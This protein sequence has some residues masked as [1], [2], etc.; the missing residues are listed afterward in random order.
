MLTVRAARAYLVLQGVAVLAFWA[1]PI[2]VTHSNQAFLPTAASPIFIYAFLPG[3]TIVV[4]FGSLITAR[5]WSG[6]MPPRFLWAIGGALWYTTAYL[7]VL[8]TAGEIAL[9]APLLMV[10]ASICTALCLAAR[11]PV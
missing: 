11:A 1:L 8:F 2:V 9:A 4:G 7:V 5:L 10:G 3:D 6:P